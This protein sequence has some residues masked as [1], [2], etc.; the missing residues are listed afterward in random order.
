MSA[1]T[2]QKISEANKGPLNPNA[3][4]TLSAEGRRR[5]SEAHRGQ[6]SGGTNT[7]WRGGRYVESRSGYVFVYVAD[8]HPFVSM[9]ERSRPY[10]PEH[11]LVMA[12][13]VG[14]PLAAEEVVHHKLEC[15]GGSG[16]KDDNRIEN[17]EVWV[18]KQPKGQRPEDLVAWAV[19][20]LE[21]HGYVVTKV[22]AGA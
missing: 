14:R 19:A 17:L 9:R 6:G 4:R 10:A 1:A 21:R 18:T 8:D 22:S 2:R 13:H 16:L 12:A 15:E 3:G 20:F 5:L 11:R 7:N